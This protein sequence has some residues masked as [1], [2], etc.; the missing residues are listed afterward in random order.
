MS[1][2]AIALMCIVILALGFILNELYSM[3][4]DAINDLKIMH[5]HMQNDLQRLA[6]FTN[7]LPVK[8]SEKNKNNNETK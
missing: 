2:F 6:E 3:V 8:R 5:I 1:Y 4:Q 7:K